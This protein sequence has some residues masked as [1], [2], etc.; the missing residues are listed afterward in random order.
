MTRVRQS[1]P[2]VMVENAPARFI[3]SAMIGASVCC[4]RR[5]FFSFKI[6]KLWP[7]RSYAA[8]VFFEPAIEGE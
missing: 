6:V 5:I 8:T 1:G 2:A 7:F 3:L 4:C